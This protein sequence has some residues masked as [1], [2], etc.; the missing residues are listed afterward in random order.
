[1]YEVLAAYREYQDLVRDEYHKLPAAVRKEFVGE[2]R[3][4][5][6]KAPKKIKSAPLAKRV[7]RWYMKHSGEDVGLLYYEWLRPFYYNHG[8]ESPVDQLKLIRAPVTFL[9]K[10]VG[11][12]HE[13]VVK[14]LADAEAVIKDRGWK[15]VV[16]RSITTMW[17]FVPRPQNDYVKLSNHSLGRAF[18]INPDTNPHIQGGNADKVDEVLKYLGAPTGYRTMFLKDAIKSASEAQA[19]ALH[20]KMTAISTAIQKFLKLHLAKWEEL[21]RKKDTAALR[22]DPYDQVGKLV[23]GLGGLK[24]AK[25]ARDEGVFTISLLL[26]IA[27]KKDGEKG[28]HSGT[29]W[30]KEKDPMHW[31]KKGT[32]R[33]KAQQGVLVRAPMSFAEWYARNAL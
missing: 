9:G 2:A 11:A 3:H 19:H 31:E 22:S 25:T 17:A 1:V 20:L 4:Q 28:L 29:E 23:A 15:E 8:V 13:D 26:F 24:N 30:E 33:L 32:P 21:T 10:E 7:E 18:D 12:A 16:A 6:E 14:L 27:F 5:L